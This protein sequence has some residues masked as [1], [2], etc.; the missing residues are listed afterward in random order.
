MGSNNFGFKSTAVVFDINDYIKKH[1]YDHDAGRYFYP[2]YDD[3]AKKEINTFMPSD[4]V[5]Q[6][7]EA[8]VND[9]VISVFSELGNLGFW[10]NN[11]DGEQKAIYCS[12]SIRIKHRN[13]LVNFRIVTHVKR[14][15]GYHDGY[16]FLLVVYPSMTEHN[17]RFTPLESKQVLSRLEKQ[18]TAIQ[19]K[20]RTTILKHL[21]DGVPA[22]TFFL[23]SYRNYSYHQDAVLDNTFDV[24]NNWHWWE[25]E[26]DVSKEIE[27]QLDTIT[28]Y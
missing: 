18:V 8:D 14:V 13:K 7:V 22:G 25:S 3:E 24:A 23:R 17:K 10:V 5:R 11:H 1:Y 4:K 20:R 16:A 26:S 2:L 15:F 28:T 6:Y 27:K 12:D 19:K 21:I 9:D